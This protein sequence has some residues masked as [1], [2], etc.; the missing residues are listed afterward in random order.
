M[1]SYPGPLPDELINPKPPASGNTIDLALGLP[2]TATDSD[3]L[4]AIRRL[5]DQ[6]AAQDNAIRSMPR[7][8]WTRADVVRAYQLLSRAD[9]IRDRLAMASASISYDGI[10]IELSP[11]LRDA[12]RVHADALEADALRDA[13]G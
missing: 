10:E 9:A 13:E 1:A 3:R 7:R 2:A 6:V 4:I 8:G 12:L 11:A 5:L